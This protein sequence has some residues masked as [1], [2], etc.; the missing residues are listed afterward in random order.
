MATDVELGAADLA[1]GY[2]ARGI[3]S[4]ALSHS[5]TVLALACALAVSGCSPALLTRERPQTGGCLLAAV[6]GVLR[7]DFNWLLGLE[8]DGQNHGVLWPYQ[9]SARQDLDGL[10]LLDREGRRLAKVGD[11]IQMAGTVNT[12]GLVAPCDP[13]DL[14]VVSSGPG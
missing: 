9:Y 12:E 5:L 8:W 6:G 1:G 11:T 2:G 14:T 13:P 4:G 3:T 10:V 7:S